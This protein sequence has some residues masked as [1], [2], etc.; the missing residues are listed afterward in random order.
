MRMI[1]KV[2]F[3]SFFFS[4]T[5]VSEALAQAAQGISGKLACAAVAKE[6]TEQSDT[7]DEKKLWEACWS[8]DDM[9]A[10]GEAE[11][12]L[13][14]AE[15]ICGGRISQLFWQIDQSTGTA[16]TKV[17]M[18]T[19]DYIERTNKDRLDELER[20]KTGLEVDR[21]CRGIDDS[22]GPKGSRFPGLYQP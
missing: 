16:H 1:V 12:L 19:A 2:L 10:L 14:R 3:C 20:N 7:A 17:Y 22:F 18:E 5:E 13:P 4:G 11:Y 9:Q 8:S 6:K 21:F 15:D